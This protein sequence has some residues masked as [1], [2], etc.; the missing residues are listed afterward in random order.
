M[1]KLISLFVLLLTCVVCFASCV[2]DDDTQDNGQ[3]NSGSPYG[4]ASVFIPGDEVQI[5]FDNYSDRIAAEAL[6][7]ELSPILFDGSKGGAYVTTSY[8]MNAD[9]EIIVG[10]YDETRPATVKAKALLE[11]MEKEAYFTSRYLIYAESNCVA[12]AYD[13][14]EYTNLQSIETVV[15][16]FINK[17]VVGKEY[18]AFGCGIVASGSVDLIPIQ[19]D[20]DRV[21][22]E[23]CW[24]ALEAVSSPELVEAMRKYYAMCEDRIVDWAANLYDPG[25]GGYY[26]SS[27][28]RDGAQFGPDLQNT[29]Q[30][31]RFIVNTGMVE[32]VAPTGDWK[33]FLPEIMQYRLIYWAKSLQ[34]PNGYFYHPQW[35]R[36]SVDA[37]L[38]RRGRDLGWGTSLLSELDSAPPYRAANGTAGDGISADEYWE[39]LGLDIDPPYTYDKCPTEDSI[40]SGFLT[41]GLGKS[42]AEAV[43]HIV[44][45][46]ETDDPSTAYLRDYTKFIDYMLGK[47]APGMHTNPYSYGNEI[48]ETYQQIR[49][50]SKELEDAQGKFAYTSDMPASYAPYDGMN[51]T[52]IT[53]AVLNDCINPET[54]LWGDLTA[55]CPTGT[56]FR[57]TNGF[58]KAMAAYEGFGVT[59]PT[60]YMVKAADAL[61]EGLMSDEPSTGNICEVY[62]VWVSIVRL[63]SNVNRLSS[64]EHLKDEDGNVVFDDSTGE[65]VVL[66]KYILGEIQKVFDEKAP[67]AVENSYN[68]IVEY[69]K[70]D[71]GFAH[72][73]SKGTPTHQDHPVSL[74]L[75]Q[76][77]VD[78]TSIA[79]SGTVNQMFSALGLSSY[80][81]PRYTE[82]DWMRYLTILFEMSPVIKY[83]Y[84]G[85]VVDPVYTFESDPAGNFTV[86]GNNEI[87]KDKINGEETQVL[88]I[89]KTST[90]V[91]NSVSFEAN[92]KSAAA[93]VTVFEADVKYAN[94]QNLSE[95]QI[96]LVNSHNDGMAFSP[97]LILLTFGGKENGSKIFYTDY[98]NGQ[99]N[100]QRLDTGAV[101][102]SWFNIRIE[103][104]E[105]TAD[106][107]CYKTYINNKI[108]YTSQNIYSQRIH[109]GSYALPTA[110]QIDKVQ[111][112]M[113]MRFAGEFYFDNM[114]LTQMYDENGTNVEGG[115]T[116]G[117]GGSSSALPTPGDW[118]PGPVVTFD[119]MPP[120]NIMSVSNQDVDNAYYIV[121]TESGNKVMKVEKLSNSSFSSAVS[122]VQQPTVID[123]TV[124]KVV[125]TADILLEN[126]SSVSDI[127]LTAKYN[128]GSGLTASPFLILLTPEKADAG[129]KLYYRDYNNGAATGT[130]LDS[131]AVVGKWFRL[132]LEYTA[133][134]DDGFGNPSQIEVK[135]YVNDQLIHTSNARYG[136]SLGVNGGDQ[137]IPGASNL[138]SMT[139][140]F[141][142]LF[143]GDIYVDNLALYKTSGEFVMPDVDT[144]YG[145]TEDPDDGD[146]TTPDDGE[147]TEP[148]TV[149]SVI[150]FDSIPADNALYHSNSYEESTYA[151]VTEGSGNKVLA[152]SKTH[153]N[154]FSC[155]YVLRVYPTVKDENANAAIFTSDI[156]LSELTSSSQIQLTLASSSGTNS[157]QSPFM[158][159]LTPSGLADESVIKYSDNSGTKNLETDAVVGTWF[160]LRLEYRTAQA[161]DGTVEAIEIKTFV[162]D[163]LVDTSAF[164]YGSELVPNGGEKA[165]PT[166]QDSQYLSLSFNS[167]LAGTIKVDNLGFAL[168]AGEFV[169]PD[170]DTEYG[171]TEDPDEGG[172]P[173]Q[174]TSDT[175]TFDE[176]PATSVLA[177][178]SPGIT[179]EGIVG[180]NEWS[181][182]TVGEEKV[183]HIVKGATGVDESG[184]LLNYNCGVSLSKP[185]TKL[186]DNAN[187]AVYEA[188][189]MIVS[190]TAADHIQILFNDTSATPILGLF[191]PTGIEV[192]SVIK[193]E[194]N[195]TASGETSAKVGEWFHIRVEYRVTGSDADGNATSIEVKY[196]IGDD[197]AIVS[198]TA[199]KDNL[200]KLS[201]IKTC[202]LAFNRQY[203]GEFYV[204]NVSFRLEYVE[205]TNV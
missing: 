102:G 144:E 2:S 204:D 58:M 54:G 28:G 23:E 105:G 69:K 169:V 184:A 89:T 192:G 57:Y 83:S 92:T 202:S 201:D 26:A 176:L 186:S 27:S 22:I 129:S 116:G 87:V 109:S 81:V 118:V 190:L 85:K 36:A 29:V 150:T 178:A 198:T 115:G 1:K 173:E 61:M 172:E 8:A 70:Y 120:T 137:P 19:E 126:L 60:E 163:T 155:A 39:S 41:E 15:D 177:V 5:V 128:S 103:Y 79:V 46:A 165:V 73:V 98:T 59:Y 62:N 4:K 153:D 107:F 74:G 48:G 161:S 10:L 35:A 135:T 99:D 43:S 34:D 200:M 16:D 152:I 205:P 50:A 45:A 6:K 195:G 197:E 104:Y 65:P 106:T 142:R 133:S 68:K 157:K 134:G 189:V 86:V 138:Y 75:N 30:M 38:S 17:F 21:Y 91:G 96:T 51:L 7:S 55:S 76:S 167:K 14:N 193:N 72:N 171:K 127:Q 114:S 13:L 179:A 131:G 67:F 31:I 203:K 64:T 40:R 82:S 56:E 187:V 63:K 33:D 44:L 166:V 125:F 119:G 66:K 156:L 88:K 52:E 71:G 117:S 148:E 159:L 191:K 78:A 180:T 9:L 18:L 196:F 182:A 24:A 32:F 93:N 123:S 3:S 25:V 158:I 80:E 154:T 49:T 162:N 84:D 124:E 37:H 136:T 188:D 95:T 113:N 183:L 151:I 141:N 121:A 143:L 112:A 12:I 94:L 194:S 149:T 11:K 140:S 101:V 145:K 100:K 90:D 139:L 185:I 97:V 147:T 164:V 42:V 199:Y 174:T 53:V 168:T 160:R 77:D 110:D 181:I 170:V 132:R 20:I 122:F 47:I 111:Y 130:M 108:I 175:V 146:G